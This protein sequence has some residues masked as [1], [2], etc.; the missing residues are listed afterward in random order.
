M[1]ERVTSTEHPLLLSKRFG[2]IVHVPTELIVPALI[3]RSCAER[4]RCGQFA[5][6]PSAGAAECAPHAHACGTYGERHT[7]RAPISPPA[8][9]GASAAH[10]AMR[11]LT[12]HRSRIDESHHVAS[13]RRPRASRTRHARRSRCTGRRRNPRA[14]SREFAQLS[15]SRRRHRQA[16]PRR[17]AH[18]NV[19]RRRCRRSDRRRRHGVRARRRGRVDLFSVLARR[20]ADRRGLRDGPGRRCRRLRA[21]VGRAPRALVHACAA[22]LHARASRDADDGGPHRMARAR[23]RRRPEGGRQ[24]ARARHG[25]R[26]DLRAAVREANGR[27]RD[28]HV[29]VGRKAGTRTRARRRSRRQLSSR[30]ELGGEGARADERARRRPRDRGR[31][32]RHAPAIDPGMP[33]RRPYRTDRRADG[34]CRP[35]ADRRA[36]GAPAEPARPD[37][38]QSPASDRHGARDRRNRHQ[39][40]RRSHV[41]ARRHRRRVRPS[42]GRQALRQDLPVDLSAACAG[43]R[44]AHRPVPRVNDRIVP[45]R[46]AHRRGQSRQCGLAGVADRAARGHG[47]QH[48]EPSAQ[49]VAVKPRGDR[50]H[51]LRRR[52]HH[53]R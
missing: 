10:R 6:P 5:H 7:I 3:V 20:R 2:R 17:Q 1:T 28:R 22:G 35:G 14:H 53:A 44:S 8:I 39:A 43:R 21:R 37:R 47:E 11:S 26:I 29:V 41:R 9:A 38:R 40:G 27:D 19:R 25:R 48:V 31:R 34:D 23:R 45:R 18:S 52:D 15:R 49:R 12:T 50:C 36:D 30:R 42:S 24:R 51:G 4:S 33:D 16:E 32:P 46:E 13:T